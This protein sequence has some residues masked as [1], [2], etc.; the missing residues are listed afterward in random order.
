MADFSEAVKI[1]L[2]HE[3]GYVDNPADPGGATNMGIEQKEWNRGDIRDLTVEDAIEFYAERYWPPLYNQIA[4]QPVANK[5]FDC[6]VFLG[7]GTAVR[8]LQMAVGL[9]KCD[10]LFGPQ[11]LQA[12]NADSNA[13]VKFKEQLVIY[14]QSLIN[15]NQSLQEFVQGWLNRVNS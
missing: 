10:G 6:G 4:S 11:T 15:R 2:Q 1:T 13:L 7:K 14:V 3:G 9:P 12:V 5:L 8:R